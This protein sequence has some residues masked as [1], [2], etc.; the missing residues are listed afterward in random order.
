MLAS[1]RFVAHVEKVNGKDWP[2]PKPA[3]RSGG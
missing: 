2:L 1:L 3:T